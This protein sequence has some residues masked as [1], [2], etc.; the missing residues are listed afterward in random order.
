M[1]IR[2]R[3]SMHVW[4]R[5]TFLKTMAL[6]GA[7][8]PIPSRN[9]SAAD[10]PHPPSAQLENQYFS[11]HFDPATG[12]FSVWRQGGSALLVNAASIAA[13]RDLPCSTADL[14][15][16]RETK[17]SPFQTQLGSGRQLTALCR[18][19]RRQFDF[20]VRLALFDNRQTVQ[21]EVIGRNVSQKELLLHTLCPVQARLEDQAAL[22]WPGA[23]TLLTNGAIYYDAGR[24]RQIVPGE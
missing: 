1:N 3:M 4:P 20:E 5:R 13:V 19:R 15:Y 24:V 2:D 9:L 8:I 22:I 17:V 11:V 7:A 18:D 23:R 10:P 14:R 6:A 21:I 16:A 12:R